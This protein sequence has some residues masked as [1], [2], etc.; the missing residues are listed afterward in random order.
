MSSTSKLSCDTTTS[1]DDCTVSTTPPNSS[2]S[3]LLSNNTSH[4]LSSCTSSYYSCDESQRSTVRFGT[5]QIRQY[6]VTTSDNPACEEGPGISFGWEY[7]DGIEIMPIELFESYRE[8]QRL[9]CDDLYLPPG[10]RERILK[11]WNVNDDVIKQ[12][13]DERK[14]IQK[15]RKET[16]K[17]ELKKIRRRRKIKSAWDNFKRV[18]CIL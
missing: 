6:N 18:L 17:R 12:T 10:C 4:S 11:L 7:S 8:G 9:P 13:M 16:K 1:S 15:Q 14:V 2:K 5:I 3:I